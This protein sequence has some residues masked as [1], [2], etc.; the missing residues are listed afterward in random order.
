M[1]E[2]ADEEVEAALHRPVPAGQDRRAQLE[3]R[4]A[5]AGHVLAPLDEELG[6]VGREP[7]LD[8]R[9]VR[10]LDDLEHR[11]LVEVGFREDHLV[12]PHLIEHE[13]ELGARR[14]AAGSPARLVRRDDADELVGE[15]AARRSERAA[16]AG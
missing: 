11:P 3:E 15:P 1:H 9:A 16:S 10:L 13:R 2:R 12:R 14:R 5:L 6:R 8:P 7:H 4:R